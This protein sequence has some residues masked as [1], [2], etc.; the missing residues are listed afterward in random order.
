MEEENE[1]HT[2]TVSSKNERNTEIDDL[3]P[4]AFQ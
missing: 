4:F 1:K 3:Q 2:K